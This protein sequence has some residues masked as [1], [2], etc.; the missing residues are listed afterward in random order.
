MIIFL[1][2]GFFIEDAKNIWNNLMEPVG[3]KSYWKR[4][5]ALQCPT[6]E[7]P[8]LATKENSD[9]EQEDAPFERRVRRRR[10]KRK[11]AKRSP[12]FD[13]ISPSYGDAQCDIL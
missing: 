1:N 7:R 5:A 3:A 12:F 9:Y 11:R 4:Y 10:R 2:V 13:V 6:S 8:F